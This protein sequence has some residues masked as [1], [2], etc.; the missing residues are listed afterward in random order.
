MTALLL[1]LSLSA[2]VPSEPSLSLLGRFEITCPVCREP[3]TT[4]S[5]QRSNT[6]GGVDRDLFARAL[7]PQ[8]EYYRISTC[9]A[10][11]YSGYV[12]DFKPDV[13]LTPD[14]LQKILIKPKLQVPEG[15]GPDSDPRELD[16]SDRYRL[17]ILCYQWRRQSDEA[18]GW[19]YLRASWIARD[20]G[21]VLP[22]DPRLA[23]ML[24]YAERWRPLMEPGDN[25]VD[26]ELINAT[27][28]AEAIATGHFNRYQ[29]P[30]AELALALILRRHGENRQAGPLL[31]RLAGY[32][33]F[34]ASLRQGI[35]RMRD[36]IA[37]ERRYQ[38][39]AADCFERA[40]LARLIPTQNRPAAAY[41]QG[42]LL[43]RLG[44]DGEAVRWYDA[45]LAEPALPDNLRQW[46]QT[47]RAWAT[48]D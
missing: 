13:K 4:V 45:A 39:Q 36:S 40:L 31:D 23:R 44:I 6:R 11:G 41:L 7:G 26:V 42:E 47:Q 3:F 32:D 34:S 29:K 28:I 35:P 17:A 16:A 27:G 37:T 38:Q 14:A 48:A 46:A 18:I 8:P 12:N 22:P 1:A 10:C 33:G 20:E 25:Q 5:C 15:F 9:P 43:R 30:Y 2:A 24:Q 19:L 21:A